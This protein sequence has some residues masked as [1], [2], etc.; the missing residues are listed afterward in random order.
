MRSRTSLAAGASGCRLAHRRLPRPG[1]RQPSRRRRHP[2]DGRGD[3]PRRGRPGRGLSGKVRRWAE[4]NDV[5]VDFSPTGSIDELIAVRVQGNDPPDVAFFS[6]PAMLR[7]VAERSEL[8]DLTDVVAQAD[9][10]AMHPDLLAIGRAGDAQ[11]A[12]PVGVHVKSAVFYPSA[13]A[14]VGLTQPPATLE[15]L[16]SLTDRLAENGVTP[17]RSAPPPRTR[18]VGRPPTGSRT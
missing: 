12:V 13:A 17:W 16:R 10:E 11:Y 2:E 3:V 1:R 6:Q 9:R 15:G 7:Q 14:Q 5:E 8:L 18:R 4:K